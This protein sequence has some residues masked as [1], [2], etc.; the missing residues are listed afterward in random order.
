MRKPIH[1]F[2]GFGLIVT[3]AGCGRDG[4]GTVNAT[5]TERLAKAASLV[6]AERPVH[7][8]VSAY[9][10]E[11]SHVTAENQVQVLAKGT[12]HCLNVRVEEGDVVKAGD[13]LAELD[14]AEMEAQ[15]RQSEVNVKQQKVVYERTKLGYDEGIFSRA[16]YDSAESSYE[17]AK[18]TLSMHEVQLS[19]LTITSP[20]GG[21]VTKRMLQEGMLVTS[22]MPV[23]DIVDPTSY[24]LPILITEG[25]LPR[26]RIGQEAHVTI[27]SSG[28]RE[29]LARV[30]RINPSVDSQT[31][32]VKVIL[33]FDKKDYPYLRES[34]FARY[35]LVMD[36]HENALVVP[37][38]AIVEEN[39]RR[40]V[41]V[42]RKPD[43]DTPADTPADASADDSSVTDAGAGGAVEAEKPEKPIWIAKRVEVETGLEDSDFTEI[44]SGIDA[45]SL[46]IT[47]GQQ[48]VNDGDAVEVGN[49]EE[50]L[51]S[52]DHMSA[53][54]LLEKARTEHQ[55][56]A[57]GQPQARSGGH[58][59]RRGP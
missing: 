48:T 13:V 59:S 5:N 15:L 36:T 56:D 4:S 26:L 17:Q 14:K 35:S 24:V 55:S 41:M 40:F 30:R 45:D 2:V 33:E 22:G 54:E 28:D 53:D 43:A 50:T 34:A 38:D 20:I 1:W 3:F 9:L 8:D 31:G 19:F 52:R 6:E 10:S 27:D 12:G 7:R 42:V 11:T 23:F 25:E 58:G 57:A 21:I 46:V 51:G 18:A 49:L 44:V 39:A 37:K 47:L 29:F 32:S 16:E